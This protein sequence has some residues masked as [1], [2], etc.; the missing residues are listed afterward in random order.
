MDDPFRA[1]GT[2]SVS[3]GEGYLSS[4]EASSLKPGDVVR[5]TREAGVPYAVL[6]NGQ[7][8]AQCEAV[9]LGGAGGVSIFGIRICDTDFPSPFAFGPVRKDDVGELLPFTVSLGSIRVSLRELEGVGA[10]SLISLGVPW[11]TEEDA[12][13]VVAGHPLARGKVVVKGEE[14][15]VRITRILARP[16]SPPTVASSGFLMDEKSAAHF[17]VKDYDFRR[18]DKI[19]MEQVLRLRDTHGL[20]LQN[21]RARLPELGSALQ[22]GPYPYLVDQC[23]MAEALDQLAKWGIGNRMVV[24]NRPWRRIPRAEAGAGAGTPLVLLEEEG[25]KHPLDPRVRS[26]AQE[27]LK[28]ESLVNRNVIFLFH[29]ED[30]ALH[31]AMED[32]ASALLACLRA[33]WRTIVELN[34][35]KVP[36]EE[37]ER[38]SSIPA[39][40]MVVLVAFTGPDP[41]KPALALV[42]PFLT[43]EPFVRLLGR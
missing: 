29:G 39:H 22:T 35:E 40:D 14:L 41:P 27:H 20:F 19:T 37:A 17:K 34:P 32:S 21:L 16:S 23:T 5:T 36:S 25:T 38:V 8:L 43:L 2:L 28:A 42:Y 9:V 30:P 24:E 26:Y 7:P 10:N 11:S 6:Y 15:G 3:L 31:R 13:L 18:P 4:F 12:E 33:A 1:R